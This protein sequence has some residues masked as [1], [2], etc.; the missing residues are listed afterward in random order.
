MAGRTIH[1]LIKALTDVEQFETIDTSTST[2]EWLLRCR[3]TLVNMVRTV[4]VRDS[5]TITMDTVSDMAYAW[6]CITDFIGEMQGRVKRDPGVVVLLRAVFLKL[7]SVL[8]SP[9]VRILQADSPDTVS[10]AEYYSSEMVAFVRK[11]LEIVPITVFGILNHIISLQT[12]MQVCPPR[13]LHVPRSL[14]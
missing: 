10:V 8:D 11:V 1:K 3:E 5:V 13:P 12:K 7:T 9:L 4:N 2:K 14:L 6:Q